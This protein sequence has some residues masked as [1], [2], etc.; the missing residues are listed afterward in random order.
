VFVHDAQRFQGLASELVRVAPRT[1][2]RR[3]CCRRAPRTIAAVAGRRLGQ[4]QEVDHLV[5][6]EEADRDFSKKHQVPPQ[7]RDFSKK[8][9]Y[10]KNEFGRKYQYSKNEFG[11]K[12]QYSK[13]KF[14]KKHQ[15]KSKNKI[16]PETSV[17]VRA[18]VQ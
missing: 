14:R 11:T 12:Y 4:Q 2:R 3:R 18:I 16:Q 1:H 6:Q 10:S 13:N 15:K 17:Q 8:Y 5:P 7:E 9:Q